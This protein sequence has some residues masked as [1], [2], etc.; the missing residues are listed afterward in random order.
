MTDKGNINP[1]RKEEKHECSCQLNP[2]GCLGENVIQS[3]GYQATKDIFKHEC[4]CRSYD[5]CRSKKHSCSC[6]KNTAG[7]KSKY[8]EC[9][10]KIKYNY[11]RSRCHTCI[12][13]KRGRKKCRKSSFMHLFR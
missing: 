3:M 11:C 2:D 8:H 5:N 12:C 13:D 10:C 7:C 4:V 1:C 9:T 6:N